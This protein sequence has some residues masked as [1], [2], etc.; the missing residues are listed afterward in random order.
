MDVRVRNAV[1]G[2]LGSARVSRCW[3]RRRAETI[4]TLSSATRGMIELKEKFAIAERPRH[5]ARRARSP[6][7]TNTRETYSPRRLRI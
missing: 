1:G 7:C 4:F 6:E 2:F 5:Y 3:F